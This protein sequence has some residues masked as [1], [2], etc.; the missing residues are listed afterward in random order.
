MK[1]V[2]NILII[3]GFI[4]IGNKLISQSTTLVLRPNS[5]TGKDA[6]IDSR[7]PTTNYGFHQDILATAWTNGGTPTNGRGLVQFDL[8]S[9][10][11]S[12][13]IV[14]ASLS[15]YSHNSSSNGT[16]STS[17][18]S[19]QTEIKRITSSWNENTVTW[20]NQPTTTNVNQVILPAS[21]S[22]IQHYLN[23]NVRNLVQDMVNNPTTSHG[24]LLKLTTESYYRKMV[25]ASSDNADTNLYP[26]LEIVFL[27]NNN[28]SDS[29]FTFRPNSLKGKDAI[30]DSRVPTTNYGFHQDILATAWTNGGTPT[31]GRGL[32]QFDLAGVIPTGASITLSE[33]SLYSHN[34]SSNGTHSTSSGSN[35]TEIK[36][37]TSPWNENTVT[38]GNQPTTTNVNQVILPASTSSI[39]HYLNINVKNLVQ[40]MVNNPTTSHGFLLKLTTESYYRKMVFASSDN[41]DTNLYPKLKVCY[42][43]NSTKLIELKNSFKF[44]IYP[45]PTSDL[46]F[47]EFLNNTEE[48]VYMELFNSIGEIVYSRKNINANLSIDVSQFTKGIYFMKVYSNSLVS[49]KKVVIK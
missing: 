43:T 18:G 6:I 40:D 19:N 46:L 47:V 39:Q 7:V 24:F 49:A 8:T 36:R 9:I 29:C 45:N 42:T 23:I 25:F 32:V 1:S 2:R 20:G 31:N 22:S 17:S 27:T 44:N 15:L 38:W 33:L 30:I 12:A 16:H 41:A 26:K 28:T 35:Q 21:T 34:S 37:I 3:L 48:D 14:S 5:V 11:T 13:T 4:F 10:P